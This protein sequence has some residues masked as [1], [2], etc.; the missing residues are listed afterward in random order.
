MLL[1]IFATIYFLRNYV[2]LLLNFDDQQNSD[3]ISS[4]TC[5]IKN[6]PLLQIIFQ[7]NQ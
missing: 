5:I 4:L 1:K 7:E 2:W 3:Y 6:K